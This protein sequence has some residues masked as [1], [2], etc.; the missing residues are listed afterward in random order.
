MFGEG[1]SLSNKK[2]SI[3]VHEEIQKQ[4][5]NARAL[6]R[7]QFDNPYYNLENLPQTTGETL[8]E[9]EAKLLAWDIGWQL[10]D[11]MRN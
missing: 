9:W 5:A 4:G 7:N 8:T 1:P 3:V 10:E 2:G 11:M 6:N